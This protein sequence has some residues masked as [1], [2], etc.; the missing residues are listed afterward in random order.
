MRPFDALDMPLHGTQ[1]VEASAGTGKTFSLAGLYLRLLV[2][3]QLEVSQ[4]LVMTFTRA[5]TQELRERI[6]QR[7][8]EAAVIARRPEQADP[9]RSEQ[10]FAL[11]LIERSAR[12]PRAIAR[13]LADA[14]K[15]MDEAA[16]TTI[17]GF[18][19]RA[20]SENAFASGLPFDRGEQVDDRPLLTEAVAD[21]WRGQALGP[22]ADAAFRNWWPAPEKLQAMLTEFW[23]RP[24]ARLASPSLQAIEDQNAKLKEQWARHGEQFLDQCR[25]CCQ[26]NALY[27]N[28]PLA[29]A[30]GRHGELEDAL[31]ALQHSLTSARPKLPDWVAQLDCA[32]KQFK[33]AHQVAGQALFDLSLSRLLCESQPLGR[34]A[35]LENARQAISQL[36]QQRKARRRQF[37]FNDMIG[38]LHGAITDPVSGP[39]LAD[40][41]NST[42]PWALVD[43]FQDTDPL[44]YEILQRCHVNRNGGL[45]LIGDPKQAIYGFRG[46]DV[47]A[48]LEAAR[49]ARQNSYSLATNF[50]STQNL[51]DGVEALFRL[52]GEG[53]FL[54]EGIEFQHVK[55][56]RPGRREL[57]LGPLPAKALNIWQLPADDRRKPAAERACIIACMRQIQDLLAEQPGAEI[58]S[59]DAAG[60]PSGRRRVQPHDIAVLVNTNRQA[61]ELQQ[62]LAGIGIAAACQHQSSVFASEQAKELLLVLRA[63]ASPTDEKLVRG[64]LSTALLGARLG[65]LIAMHQQEDLWQAA[66]TRLQD[67]HENWRDRGVLAMLQGLIQ[68]AAARIAS[69]RDGARRLSNY[70]QL[71]EL[72][73]AAQAEV[74]GMDGLVTWLRESITAPDQDKENEE[75][76]LRLETDAA[77]VRIVTVHKSKGLEYPIVMLPFAPWLGAAGQPDQPPLRYHDQDKQALIDLGRSDAAK[78]AAILETRGEAL[79]LLYVALTR[80]ELACYLPWGAVNGSQNGA[81]ASLLHREL[82]SPSHWSKSTSCGPLVPDEITRA[83][84]ELLQRAPHA[85]D[86]LLPAT[87]LRDP[88]APPGDGDQ[89]G[90]A[91]QDLPAARPPW[92][93]Y[94]FSRL[95]HLGAPAYAAVG[96]EDE[97]TRADPPEQPAGT[98]EKLA[99]LPGGS[100]YGTAVH[101]LLEQ[102]DN[103]AWP[104]PGTAATPEQLEWIARILRQHGLSWE[105]GAR[106]Q[107]ILQGTAD[108]LGQALHT[109]LP[110]IGPLAQLDAGGYLREM[111]FHF[112]LGGNSLAGLIARLQQAG[113]LLS[114]PRGSQTGTLNGLMHGYIDLIVEQGGRY[115][116][117][118]YKTNYLGPDEGSYTPSALQHAIHAHHYDLQYLIYLTAL[119]RYLRQR[120]PGYDPHSHLGGAQYLFLRGMA[121]H[122]GQRGIHLDRP[123]PALILDLDR[124]FDQDQTKP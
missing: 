63:A 11:Q 80:A 23:V 61:S 44:Q 22:A 93:S 92:S 5:A 59:F 97:T 115:Y 7:L 53:C 36:V 122:A 28:G 85:V 103:H 100:A 25:A 82:I 68:A 73:A 62:A 13:Q 9:N 87:S 48:Y 19:Q 60:L 102:V 64:A 54:V 38:A 117:I 99:E 105:P 123:D 76:Q 74:F 75:Q 6:R 21:Y 39:A 110:G 89:P 15:R 30:I 107:P 86:R 55:A 8:S 124:Y 71:A 12:E 96:A 118:D 78:A 109:S 43:E 32:D 57:H 70:L 111:E 37:S 34:L 79:R 51:L 81:L 108:L 116:V 112:R 1:L 95:V 26:T 33:K 83:L 10:A 50:R 16:I 120:L 14:A 56:G 20:V 98:G 40:A 4:I 90:R 47:Y 66:L 91:R 113:Y 2:E 88:V 18:A 114:L 119:H 49:D 35:A 29:V 65:D 69:Y 72:L 46:G 84:D 41:L 24:H 31:Q 27:K 94:S 77:L 104:R 52:P 58:R 3:E 106:A 42:W 101:A 45:I 67:A 17:H 121:P